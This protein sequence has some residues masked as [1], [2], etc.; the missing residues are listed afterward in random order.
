M[1]SW[2]HYL[3]SSRSLAIYG[4]KAVLRVNPDSWLGFTQLDS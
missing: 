4:E 1:R 3:D 2:G